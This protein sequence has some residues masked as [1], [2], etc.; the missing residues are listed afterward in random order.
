MV[1]CTLDSPVCLPLNIWPGY[2]EK[3]ALVRAEAKMTLKDRSKAKVCVG[4]C[5]RLHRLL[6]RSGG[7]L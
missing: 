6:F 3:A 7:V 5:A 1:S 4:L 2:L